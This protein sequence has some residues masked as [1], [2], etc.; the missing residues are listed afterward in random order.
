MG[1]VLRRFSIQWLVNYHQ[2]GSVFTYPY[3]LHDPM[4]TKASSPK[5]FCG[6]S[7]FGNN[8][9]RLSG[10]GILAMPLE[11]RPFPPGA[12]ILGDA[13]LFFFAVIRR[14]RPGTRFVMIVYPLIGALVLAAGEAR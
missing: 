7:N 14:W 6:D 5:T 1:I 4:S 10:A 11:P 2:F 3:I 8:H 13:A 12:W 9:V